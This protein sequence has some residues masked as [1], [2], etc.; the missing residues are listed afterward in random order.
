MG[1]II[2]FAIV[3]VLLHAPLTTVCQE[4]AGA[5]VAES[6]AVAAPDTSK[7]ST[8]TRGIRMPPQEERTL[9]LVTTLVF[10]AGFATMLE[11]KRR[12]ADANRGLT[13]GS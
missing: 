10:L 6:T 8:V 2:R 3:L 11:V 1:G 5:V 12:R 13:G 4:P 9:V 7:K